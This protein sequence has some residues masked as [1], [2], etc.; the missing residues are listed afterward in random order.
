MPNALH[1]FLFS[2]WRLY[3]S[4]RNVNVKHGARRRNSYWPSLDLL[5]I[6]AMCGVF[7]IFAIKMV[8]V[9]MQTREIEL[10]Q[11]WKKKTFQPFSPF[12]VQTKSN[13]KRT[14]NEKNFSVCCFFSRGISNTVLYNVGTRRTA[15]ILYGIGL[16]SISSVWLPNHMEKNMS[17]IER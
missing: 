17:S 7:H 6:W 11:Q 2:D 5:L 8:A 15:V 9:R 16:G 12:C 13:K 10:Q 3:R 14:H 4:Y 1:F